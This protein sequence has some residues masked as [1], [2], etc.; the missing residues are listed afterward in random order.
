MADGIAGTAV[1]AALLSA[2]LHAAWNA[3]VKASKDPQGAMAAQVVASGLIALPFLFFLPLP[4]RAAL[5]WLAGSSA[6]GFV[7]LL[8]L[9]RGYALGRGF[10]LVY[11]LARAISPLTVLLL[12]SLLE[13]E[14]VGLTG[15]FGVALVSSGVALFA[16]G[17]GRG[18][19]AALRWAVLAGIA[20]A[21]YALCDANGA[22]AS[23]S[24]AGYG[25]T[26]ALVN[27]VI[28]GSFHGVRSG[29]LPGKALRAHWGVA[30]LGSG[31]AT[32]SYLLILWVWSRAPVALGAALRDTSVV[33]AALIATRLG[34]RLT[35]PRLAAIALAAAGSALIRFS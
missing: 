20:S 5:P 27:A 14:R 24:V 25:F 31:A 21:G 19:A 8:A 29:V 3:A 16:H 11:P 6:F 13:G 10:G 34:E 15:A 7:A 23:P 33:F 1:A 28:F 2:F 32:L 35:P 12:A 4:G 30:S 17:E 26:A 18:R 9:L 22:R